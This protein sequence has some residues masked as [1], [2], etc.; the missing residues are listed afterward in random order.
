MIKKLLKKNRCLNLKK[1][2]TA[3]LKGIKPDGLLKV[4]DRYK[5]MTTREL[6]YL[7]YN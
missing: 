4:I 3:L 7:L 1:I 2:R 6:I 5:V